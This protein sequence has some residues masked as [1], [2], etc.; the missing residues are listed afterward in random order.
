MKERTKKSEMLNDLREKPRV[1][2]KIPVYGPLRNKIHRFT[3]PASTGGST[4]ENCKVYHLIGDERRAIR[5][6][7]KENK[8]F[9]EYCM[10]R[11]YNNQVKQHLEGVMLEI[12]LEEYEV[13]KARGEI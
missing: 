6:F 5:K 7:I 10:E 4:G 8:K 11:E 9:C 13:M 12:F 2:I 1:D 3:V